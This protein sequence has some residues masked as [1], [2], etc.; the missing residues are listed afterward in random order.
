MDKD[1]ATMNERMVIGV[2]GMPG[3]GK[4]AIREITQKMGY[5]AVVMGDE[6]REEAKRR[7]L[8]PTPE[9]LG[10]IMLKLRE[11]KGPAAVAKRC[12]PKIKK[13]DGK[14]VVV[15]GIRSL[16]E[17]E[18]FKKWSPNFTL[19]A[20]HASPETRFRRLFQRRRTDDPRGWETFME[21]DL[22]ELSVGLGAVIATADHMIVNEGT[23]AQLKRKTREVLGKVLGKWMK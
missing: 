14:V 10:M 21:R 6:I 12:F 20:I 8:K 7:K 4:A 9:N 19:I 5:P 2:A 11:K 13:A 15:E 22:R 23:K 18:E 3:A 16:H 1:D 17:V